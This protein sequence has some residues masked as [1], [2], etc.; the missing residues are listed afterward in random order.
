MH[1][2]PTDQKKG[3]N[4][5][6]TY[7]M[8]HSISKMPSKINRSQRGADT[9]NQHQNNTKQTIHIEL[10]IDLSNNGTSGN[11]NQSQPL[12][13]AQFL[14]KNNLMNSYSQQ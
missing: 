2:A 6:I 3:S 1:S 5:S 11:H 12:T 9:V 7:S 14:F 8:N 13:T 10:I 4:A